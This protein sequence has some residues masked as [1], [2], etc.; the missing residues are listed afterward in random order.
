MSVIKHE[1]SSS[2][3]QALRAMRAMFAGAPKLKF[4]PASRAA[5]DEIIA[6]TP[7]PETVRFEQG[8]V[9]GVPGWWCR[10]KHADDTAVVLYLHGGGYVIG[11]AAAY[12]NFVGHIAERAGAAAFVADY[13]LAPERPF[14]AATN[15][16]R[17]LHEGL[18]A[19]GY[20]RIA[21]CGDSA[22]AGLALSFLTDGTAKSE[23]ILGVV[24]MSP[25]IDLSVSGESMASRAEEDPLLSRATLAEAA[26]TYLGGHR[27]EDPRLAT[28]DGDFSMLPPVRIHVGD[29]EVLL[30]DSLR[31]ARKAE[32]AG[33]SCE[34]HVWEGMTHVFPSSFT[35]LHAAAEAL[36]DIGR[37]LAG[38]LSNSARHE[39][40]EWLA[41]AK[42]NHTRSE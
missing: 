21:L 12:R 17:A 41:R 39:R 11:S 18:L 30:D 27:V 4:E 3:A 19:R 1:I 15:D 26:A 25:W 36:E 32:Q 9:G 37:F 29:A 5:F 38:L 40:M 33:R 7:P 2:D 6:R 14:P 16:I 31:F 24:A 34:V 42:G 20:E 10:P 35:M 23:R 13:A 8:E 28:L 22:G